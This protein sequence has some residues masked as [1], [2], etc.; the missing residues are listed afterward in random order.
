M[1]HQMAIESDR[2]TADVIEA[3]E[4]PELSAA[5]AVSGVP[6]IVVNDRVELLGS[7]PESRFLAAILQAVKPKDEQT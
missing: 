7:Q 6:K 4:F 5:Y 1:A 3:N 2:V